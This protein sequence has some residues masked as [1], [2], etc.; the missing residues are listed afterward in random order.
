MALNALRKLKED[1]ENNTSY[2]I[3]TLNKVATTA[4]QS[5]TAAYATTAGLAG[6]AAVAKTGTS[7]SS[8]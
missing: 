1:L 5:G 2:E 6:T 4:G 7:G 8:L 3:G